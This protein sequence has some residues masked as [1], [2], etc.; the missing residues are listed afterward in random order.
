MDVMVKRL[1]KR[2]PVEVTF[3][4]QEGGTAKQVRGGGSKGSVVISGRRRRRRR[5]RTMVL[6]ILMTQM[7]MLAGANLRK[8][9][10]Q[11]GM[12]VYDPKTMRFD[13]PF[14]TGNCAGEGICGTCESIRVH[15]V[16]DGR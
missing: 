15:S 4:V 10:L 1:V 16:V 8:E 13:Q 9:M 11:Q 7:T 6:M 12:P 2:Q 14:V 5:R 3:T